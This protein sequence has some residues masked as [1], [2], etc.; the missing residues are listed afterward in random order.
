MTL[1]EHNS[2]IVKAFMQPGTDG[3]ILTG[4]F[5][6]RGAESDGHSLSL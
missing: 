6:S 3:K 4:R 5:V 1:K 2:W